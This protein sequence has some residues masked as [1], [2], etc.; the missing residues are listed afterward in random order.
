MIDD[1]SVITRATNSKY[2]VVTLSVTS[3]VLNMSHVPR[4][5]VYVFVLFCYC[6][7]AGMNEGDQLVTKINFTRDLLIDNYENLQDK[8]EELNGTHDKYDDL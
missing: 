7:Q 2:G 8:M 1:L 4:G 5:F 3:H 6:F